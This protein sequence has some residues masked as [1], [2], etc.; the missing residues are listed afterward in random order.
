MKNERL[1]LFGFIFILL[2]GIL[3]ISSNQNDS[4]LELPKESNK[5]ILT[6]FQN[7]FIYYK[8]SL[9]F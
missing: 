9:N 7:E 6:S 5:S 8:N 2:I 3:F 4:S 1:K